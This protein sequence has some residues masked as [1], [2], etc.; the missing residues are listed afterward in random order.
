[1]EKIISL[2]FASFTIFG[3]ILEVLVESKLL[4]AVRTH[5][6]GE[7]GEDIAPVG[8][9]GVAGS[10]AVIFGLL[11]RRFSSWGRC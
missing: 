1:L 5:V 4:N 7:V 6:S 11:G 9:C 10:V 3:F 2:V 8:A